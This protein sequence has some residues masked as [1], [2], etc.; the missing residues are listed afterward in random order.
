MQF[1]ENIHFCLPVVK[2]STSKYHYRNTD[3]VHYMFIF[4]RIMEDTQD[5]VFSEDDFKVY[6]YV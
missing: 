5:M 1:V 2:I 4:C 3:N 6:R